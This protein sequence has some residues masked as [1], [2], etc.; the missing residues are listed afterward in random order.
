MTK[1]YEITLESGSNNT[2]STRKTFASLDEAVDWARE[3]AADWWKTAE[4]RIF[5][6]EDE[7]FVVGSAN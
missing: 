5:C 2:F 4:Y 6:V 1:T 7:E 3:F